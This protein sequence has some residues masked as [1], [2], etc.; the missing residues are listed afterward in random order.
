MPTA[1]VPLSRGELHVSPH[2]PASGTLTFDVLR[3]EHGLSISNNLSTES[4]RVL[5]DYLTEWL[6]GGAL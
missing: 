6:D 2:R 1:V 5:R 4:A 3:G